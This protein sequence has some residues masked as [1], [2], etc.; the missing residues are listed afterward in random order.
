LLIAMRDQ[1]DRVRFSGYDVANFKI[2]VFCVAA[3]FSALGGALFTLQV[4]FMSP[5]LIGIVP[6]IEMVVFCAV[7]GRLSLVGAVY[8]AILI[9]FAKTYLSESFPQLWLIL[10]GSIFIGVVMFFPKG[11]AGLWEDYGP[12][13]MNKVK[14]KPS[15]A[16]VT[17][18]E[19]KT[20]DAVS[21][22]PAAKTTDVNVSSVT[23]RGY[24]S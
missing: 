4:G 21:V 6:S 12:L 1:E 11:L 15:P 8:G 17:Q 3:V 22:T 16:P 10:M 20:V 2:F 19:E 5:S 13:L 14:K 9:N 18:T 7:G 24:S 23:A